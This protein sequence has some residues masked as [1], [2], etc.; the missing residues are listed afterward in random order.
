[1]K[2]QPSG[3][4]PEIL[5]GRKQPQHVER[6]MTK[7]P[8]SAPS[9]AITRKFR[10]ALTFQQGRKLADAERAY[11]EIL[12][13]A[14]EHFAAL[15]MLGVVCHQTGRYP[16][17]VDLIRRAIEIDPGVAAAH[18]NLGPPLQRL[19]R[20]DE[21][22]ASYDRA[23]ELK[24]D[25]A[26][27]LLNRGNVLQDLHRNAEALASYERVLALEPDY[28]EALYNRGNA[29]L[30]L[31][32][33]D[34]AL[35]SYD[36]ALAR[37]P[38]YPQALYNR[39]ITLQD[40][41]RPDDAARSFAQLLA[42]APGHPY[43]KGRLLHARMHCCD[44][45][46]FDSGVRSLDADVRAGKPVVEPFVYQGISGSPGDLRACAEIL[47]RERFPQRPAVLWNGERYHNAKIRIGY[48]SGEFRTQATSILMTELFELHDRRRFELFA[49]DN[50]WDDATPLRRRIE[51]AFDEIVDIAH[52]GDGQAAAL[53]RQR[54]IEILIDLNGFFGR[55]RQGLFSRRP[56]PVQVN[57]LGYPGT[58]GTPWIDYIVAD[59]HVIPPEHDACYTEKVVRLPDTY[60]VNDRKR[61]IAAETPTR[62]DAGL[63]DTGFVFCCFNNNYKITPD[64]FALWMRLLATIP[65]SVLW[66]LEPNAAAARNLRREARSH[67]V[68]QQRLVFAPR[69]DLAAHLARHRLADLFLDTLPCNA[70]TTASDALWAGLPVLTC[71]GGAFSGRVAGSLLNAVG[72]PE[73]V[74]QSLQEY[75]TL[76]RRLATTPPLLI[77]LREKL[78]RN[79][80]SFPLFDTDRF[81]RHIESAYITMWER[82]QRGEPPSAFS[83]RSSER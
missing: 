1:L 67:G 4:A 73:L 3:V 64:V 5:H 42:R 20:L 75:E 17:A 28:A 27:A 38:D 77:T 66:L 50:G 2:L 60:Q 36:R 48:V 22:L 18:V 81:R 16:A 47:V 43:A 9:D 23:L 21:A 53:V 25:Y 55:A 41:K 83:V 62:A 52:M 79:R 35:A 15:H 19:Q 68:A 51:A 46:D 30:D 44:W 34:E 45:A 33:L 80:T 58:L 31:E 29:L 13:A 78:W 70:H 57:Y 6:P 26:N 65:D 11:R 32:R 56:C 71:L 37:K 8:E 10:Q 72:M 7:I 49:I 39:A 12:A 76:A 54:N 69:V 82:Y 59:R 40:L 63:P 61:S 74:T 14:P 24:P